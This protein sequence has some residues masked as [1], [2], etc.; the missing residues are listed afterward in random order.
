MA[1]FTIF[2]FGTLDNTAKTHDIDIITKFQASCRVRAPFDTYVIDGPGV[3]GVEVRTNSKVA[4]DRIIEWLGSKNNE[5]ELNINLA[6]FS[7]GAVTCIHIANKL[8]E[9]ITELKKTKQNEILLEK[10]E[11]LKLNMFLLDPVAGLTDKKD[12][13]ARIIP[14]I[15]NEVTV[16]LQKDEGRHE[17]KPQDMTRLIFKDLSKTQVSLL[18]MYGNHTDSVKIKN[19]KIK[20]GARIAWNSLYAF[21]T[22]HGTKFNKD[23]MPNIIKNNKPVAL[24]AVKSAG[25]LL[26]LFSQYHYEKHDYEASGKMIKFDDSIPI[27]RKMRTLNNHLKFY[28]KNPKFFVNQLD[29][30]SFKI[31]YPKTFNYL[32]EKNQKDSRFPDNSHSRPHNVVNELRII[33]NNHPALF[34]RLKE[35]GFIRANGTLTSRGPKGLNY[36]EPCSSMQ[37]IFP[38]LVPECVKNDNEQ[39]EAMSRLS[40]LEMEVYQETFRYEREKSEISFAWDRSQSH[41]AEAIREKIYSIATD[42]ED[43]DQKYKLI[44]DTLEENYKDMVLKNSF[45]E[46]KVILG[47]I[48]LKHGREALQSKSNI[49]AQIVHILFSALKKSVGF[50]G[51]LGYIGGGI[52]YVVGALIEGIGRRINENIGDIGWNPL[53]AL[54]F[55]IG[56]IFQV[57]GKIIENSFG[58]KPLTEYLT[59]KIQDFRDVKVSEINKA[60]AEPI[61]A[62]PVPPPAVSVAVAQPS[63]LRAAHRHADAL[64]HSEAHIGSSPHARR[65]R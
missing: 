4:I 32:F 37:Q 63:K 6:G 53:K 18:P 58:L 19:N 31:V 50:V 23:K 15:V 40:A 42:G 12:V 17:F 7:R 64:G 57:V 10:L 62:A 60:N 26:T 44:L 16:M 56:T 36:L 33:K 3:F 13:N 30:E 41:W 52:L 59:R 39:K 47:N 5:E 28:V 20:F 8:A 61:P 45:S 2:C 65:R 48:L 54:L 25:E 27:P 1:T 46:L 11:K 34:F 55:L 38:G 35:N 22:K 51:Y 24:D 29:R 49:F 9:K 21:L 43:I 14:T